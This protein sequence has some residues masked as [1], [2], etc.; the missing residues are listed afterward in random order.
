MTAILIFGSVDLMTM[1]GKEKIGLGLMG[2]FTTGSLAGLFMFGAIPQDLSYHEFADGRAIWGIPNLFD[3]MSNI[4]FVLVGLLGLYR[5]SV[6]NK[7]KMIGINRLAYKLFFLGI[8]LVGL[9]SGYYHLAPD[10]A[11][12][13]WDRIPMTIA[14][15]ALFSVV[16]GE[17]I[18]PKTGS[19][20][21]VPL[22]VLGVLSVIYWHWTEVAGRGDL[23]PYILVQFLPMILIPVILICFESACTMVGGYWI[24]L[25][26]YVAAKIFEHFDT[27]VFALH[28]W[29]SGHSIK[30]VMAAIGIYI[31]LLA[32]GRR[33][34][35]RGN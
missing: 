11:T 9:G 7:I 16:I 3:V 32:F 13:V 30:H 34:C 2:L 17:F 25:A 10:N 29:A 20:L 24:L 33:R 4:P 23:R 27:Q 12:L 28:G 14:F 8:A 18:S 1:S 15:M 5:A 31:L 26:L 22:V 21:L 19:F 35:S 6:R